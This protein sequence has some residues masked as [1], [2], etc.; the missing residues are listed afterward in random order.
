MNCTDLRILYEDN[1]IIAVE[2]PQNIPSAP[3]SS[4]DADMLSLVREYLKIK[5]NKPGNVFVGLVHRLDRPTGGV[6]VFA[7]TSKAAER[8]SA[9]L[10]NG[11]FEKRYYA[12][13]MGAPKVKTDYLTHYLLKDGDTNT[14][15][16]VPQTTAGAKPAEL[17]YTVIESVSAQMITLSLVAVRLETGR[18]HQIRVQMSTVG[19][20]VAG[21]AKYGGGKVLRGNLALWSYQ[22][23]FPHPVT[24]TMMSFRCIPPTDDAPW[25]FFRTLEADFNV[26]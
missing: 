15:S 8:L 14:T 25:K 22:L 2:K 18:S 1:H 13:V 3:D 6:M 9:G 17:K 24:K 11:E 23:K 26:L 7:R 20:P 21:D 10:Q 12:V 19:H 5:Y 4:G 16:V